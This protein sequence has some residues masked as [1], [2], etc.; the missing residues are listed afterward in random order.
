MKKRILI[1][2]LAFTVLLA[3]CSGGQPEINLEVTEFNFGDIV[4]G[5]IASREVVVK[6]TGGSDLVISTVTTTCGCTTASL[7]P[8][9]IQAGDESVLKINFD[10]GAHGPYLTG[11]VMRRVILV[12]NDPDQSEATVDFTA[13]ILSPDSQ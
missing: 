4:N 1:I 6:N 2:L 3:A 9:T 12:S 11:E 5:V 8:M 7:E 10:S 13:N